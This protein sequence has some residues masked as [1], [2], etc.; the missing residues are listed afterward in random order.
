[1]KKQYGCSDPKIADYVEKIFKPEDAVLKEIVERTKKE[2]LPEIQLSAI[3]ALHLEVI[4]RLVGAKKAVE[5]GTLAGYSGVSI[6][7]G[8]GKAGELH[9]FEVDRKHADVAKE[10]FKKAGFEKQAIVY[11]GPALDNLPK[12]EKMGPFDL[13]FID[14]DKV[15]YPK[16][17]RWAEKNLRLGGVVV[18]DNTFAFGMIADQLFNSSSEEEDVKA[19]RAFNQEVAQG[20]H[21]LG[22]IFPTGEG[23]TVAVVIK[24]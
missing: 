16:Y 20:G 12:I 19:L 15:S 24:F 1:M 13:V 6:L 9:T 23:L 17:L 14:A 7:R 10:S 22:T 3:D 8:M 21:F 18:A 11:V 5:I 4:A 2:G